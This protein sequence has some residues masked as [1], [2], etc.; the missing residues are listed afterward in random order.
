[1]SLDLFAYKP[2]IPANINAGFKEP[3]T[4]QDAAIAIEATGV[5]GRLRG[6]VL[7][8]LRDF[9]AMSTD[10]CAAML[11]ESVLSI[12]PRF[13]ELKHAKLIEDTG[14]RHKNASG[15][16]AKVWRSV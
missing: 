10:E 6:L 16:S 15:M 5:A 7:D 14:I 3:T 11:G 12:R 4:S 1:M 2:Q 13:S 8:S 9:G